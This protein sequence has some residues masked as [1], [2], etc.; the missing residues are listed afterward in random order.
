MSRYSSGPNHYGRSLESMRNEL[1][2]LLNRR[3]SPER[4]P[5]VMPSTAFK[6]GLE[7]IKRG[8]GFSESERLSNHNKLQAA[9]S[10]NRELEHLLQ[11]NIIEHDRVVKALNAKLESQSGFQSS[12]LGSDHISLY[13]LK[14]EMESRLRALEEEWANVRSII[15]AQEQKY[16]ERPPS[17]RSPLFNPQSSSSS[18]NYSN[19]TMPSRHPEQNESVPLEKLLQSLMNEVKED[20][21]AHFDARFDKINGSKREVNVEST[22][23]SPNNDSDTNKKGSSDDTIAASLEKVVK[24]NEALHEKIIELSSTQHTH[25]EKLEELF[26]TQATQHEELS[27]KI[28]NQSEA[29]TANSVTLSDRVAQFDQL[30]A[31]KLAQ[32]DTRLDEQQNQQLQYHQL[33]QQMQQQQQQEEELYAQQEFYNRKNPSNFDATIA[34]PPL[35]RDAHNGFTPRSVQEPRP[36]QQSSINEGSKFSTSGSGSSLATSTPNV[37]QRGSLSPDIVNLDEFPNNK[38]ADAKRIEKFAYDLR[39]GLIEKD[40]LDQL[41]NVYYNS[42]QILKENPDLLNRTRHSLTRLERELGPRHKPILESI[43]R[44]L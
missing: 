5:K 34:T 12:R 9:L 24:S 6:R 23:S 1:E 40:R 41:Y 29:I 42:P 30:V 43:Q 16:Y 4:Y 33:Q 35:T 11:A 32:M 21:T 27:Q 17:S 44:E 8:Y 38:S 22:L 7:D 26:S 10:K 13:G 28:K 2:D 14:Q 20:L 36:Y 19:Y 39:H 3:K 15:L 18:A 25:S 37:Q 31:T